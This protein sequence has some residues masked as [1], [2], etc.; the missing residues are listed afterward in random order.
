MFKAGVVYA[1]DQFVLLAHVGCD[2]VD[3]TDQRTGASADET[4]SDFS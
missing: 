1:D 3:D 4:K 2:T